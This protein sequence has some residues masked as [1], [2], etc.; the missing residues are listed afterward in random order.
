MAGKEYG[1]LVLQDVSEYAF[2]EGMQKIQNAQ[3]LAECL[4]WCDFGQVSQTD[5]ML[6]FEVVAYLTQQG[7]EQAWGMIKKPT[8]E[9][10]NGKIKPCKK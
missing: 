3:S 4:K 8:I 1:D 10:I 7:L 2:L 6:A 5:V 9:I